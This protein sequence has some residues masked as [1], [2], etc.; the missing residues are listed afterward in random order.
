MTY[1]ATVADCIYTTLGP[2]NE[3]GGGAGGT[4]VP[5]KR[6]D[7]DVC[8]NLHGGDQMG[9]DRVDS[10]AHREA[11]SFLHFDLDD[12]IVGTVVDVT[13][14]LTVGDNPEAD[15]PGTG[16]LWE[17]ETFTRPDLFSGPPSRVGGSALVPSFG[18]V[19]KLE[20]VTWTLP[21]TLVTANGTVCLGLDP[22]STNGVDYFTNA[23]ATPPQ[24][25]VT[26]SQ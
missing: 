17:V 26:L 22:T 6:D 2:Q 18:P 9:V 12:R 15:G 13:L 20:D 11:E 16:D 5:A 21:T 25:I 8:R 19:D 7:P 14:A 23:G 4:P 24:L 10:I 1:P 3:G